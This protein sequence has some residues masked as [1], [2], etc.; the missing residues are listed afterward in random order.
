MEVKNPGIRHGS[1]AFYQ[2]FCENRVIGKGM[3]RKY[4][5]IEN[6]KHMCYSVCK[7]QFPSHG[8][9]S[10]NNALDEGQHG[11]KIQLIGVINQKVL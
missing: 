3:K 10:G 2:D 5:Y 1:V 7:E 4:K 6:T 9:Q 8:I 11:R